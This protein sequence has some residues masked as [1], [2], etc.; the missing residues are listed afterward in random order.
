M[1]LK[2][3]LCV[4]GLDNGQ[5]FATVS[6]LIYFA[7]LLAV[8]LFSPSAALYGVALFIG[9][10][11]ALTSIRR[12]RDSG[13]SPKL[14]V[15]TLLPF[16]LVLITL[17]HIHSMMLLLT[18]LVVAGLAIGYLALLPA[19]TGA[20]YVQGYSG[21][22]DMSSNKVTTDRASQR[23]RVEPTLGGDD[24]AATSFAADSNAESVQ[25]D[26]LA[27]Q[28]REHDSS[29]GEQ[30]SHRRRA[31]PAALNMAQLQQALQVNKKW[32][33]G[34]SGVLVSVMLIGSIWSLIPTSEAEVETA[35]LP[36][37]VIES[38]PQTE[39]VSTAMPD[40]F[41][42]VLEEDVLIMRWL[43]ETGSPT[44]LW[45]LATA[46]G[47]KTCSRMRFN[48]GTEYR[49]L[50]VDLLA[51]T[52]TEARFSPLDTEAIIVDMAR[53]GNVSLCGYNFSL[54]GS[55]AALGKVA[56]FRTYL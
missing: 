40:G 34:I 56:A 19:V 15:L 17:V 20:N 23:V 38:A 29:W 7:L 26:E 44:N 43:G 49:P 28:E 2:S 31:Q 27:Q 18:L 14:A 51:D 35:A 8:V 11:L 39:R 6:G 22:V 10:L 30:P 12:L 42:L 55:Q 3:L 1:Q 37:S 48:N 41:S 5:R 54:K 53:R 16:L 50:V 47:D 21:P 45:S 9:P 33:F 46:K 52:G 4:N 24:N 25:A 13:Q 36:E 32:L